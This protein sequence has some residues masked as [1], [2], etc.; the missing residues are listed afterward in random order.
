MPKQVDKYRVLKK[1]NSSL[2][3]SVYLVRH[4]LTG[5]EVGS[6]VRDEEDQ[7]GGQGSA[8]RG[9]HSAENRPPERRARR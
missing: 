3:A 2:H 7:E 5:Q 1:L 6:V 9:R 8:E 4:V